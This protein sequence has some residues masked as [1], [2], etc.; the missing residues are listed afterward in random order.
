MNHQP[1]LQMHPKQFPVLGVFF[2]VLLQVRNDK[3]FWLCLNGKV[4]LRLISL[5]F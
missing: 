4:E 1:P 2:L 3:I 5:T